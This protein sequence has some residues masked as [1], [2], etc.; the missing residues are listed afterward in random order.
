MK[1]TKIFLIVLFFLISKNPHFAIKQKD[2]LHVLMRTSYGIQAEQVRPMLDLSR[3]E[4]VDHILSS[5]HNKPYS[6]PPRMD[7]RTNYP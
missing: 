5:I 7:G 1:Y 4:A 2:I 3:T 6:M